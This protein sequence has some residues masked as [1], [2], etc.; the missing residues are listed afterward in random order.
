MASFARLGGWTGV[1]VGPVAFWFV[2]PVVHRIWWDVL[3]RLP[4][5]LRVGVLVVL[6]GLS[7]RRGGRAFVV[8]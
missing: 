8:G 3:R 5:F 4:C 6:V 7:Q 1:C 2:C